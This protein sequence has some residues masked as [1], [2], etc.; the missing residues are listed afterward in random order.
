MQRAGVIWSK[1][2]VITGVGESMQ[3]QKT[4]L[5]SISEDSRLELKSMITMEMQRTQKNSSA[6]EM[7]GGDLL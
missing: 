5:K 7:C 3:D 2:S 6:R 4:G 1:P